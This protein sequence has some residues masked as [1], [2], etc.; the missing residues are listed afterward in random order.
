[1]ERFYQRWEVGG[2]ADR[3]REISGEDNLVRLGC[4][5]FEGTIGC[6]GEG[7]HSQVTFRT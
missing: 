6:P 7:V 2:A 1:M 5:Q 3:G 4:C